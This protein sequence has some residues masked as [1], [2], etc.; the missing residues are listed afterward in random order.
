MYLVRNIMT[1]VG[2]DY[3]GEH[4][5]DMFFL[6]KADRYYNYFP[7]DR[8]KTNED[9]SDLVDIMNQVCELFIYEDI[10]DMT[11]EALVW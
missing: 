5:M 2:S 6:N 1:D 9:F 11:G 7:E 3:I 10:A 4:V 8:A